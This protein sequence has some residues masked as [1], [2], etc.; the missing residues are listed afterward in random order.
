MK[1]YGYLAARILVAGLFLP[2]GLNKLIDPADPAADIAGIG[3]PFPF[4]LAVVAGL[5]QAVGAVVVIVGRHAGWGALA[6][7][8][9]LAS[10]MLLMENPLIRP[11]EA[12]WFEFFKLLPWMGGLLLIALREPPISSS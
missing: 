2:A 8:G 6:L 12:T 5:V 7:M 4:F 11:D 3:L 10:V 1:D 9:F